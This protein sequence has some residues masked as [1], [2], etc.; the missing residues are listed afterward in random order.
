[1]KN[2]LKLGITASALGV[3]SITMSLLTIFV[4]GTLIL[5]I[6]S[7]LIAVLAMIVGYHA[8]TSED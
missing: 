8:A 1:M 6:G 3:V 2:Q 5:G 7:I 4:Y